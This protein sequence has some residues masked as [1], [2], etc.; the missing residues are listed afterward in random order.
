VRTR[1]AVLLWNLA[2]AVA[3]G[4]GALVFT[5]DHEDSPLATAAL[6]ISVGLA[7]VAAGLIA[8][9][10][11]PD[12]RIGLL[13]TAVGFTWFLGALAESN[14]SLLFTI[15]AAFGSI[16]FLFF[17]WLVL[18]YPSGRLLNPLDRALVGL[19]AAIAFVAHPAH[20]LVDE[21]RDERCGGAA[22]PENAF[23]VAS[24]ETLADLLLVLVQGVA[25]AVTTATVV[26]LARRWRRA[27]PALRHALT[28]VYLTAVIAVGLLATLLAADAFVDELGAGVDWVVLASL[29]AVPLAFLYGLLRTRLARSLIGRLVVE[30]GD[31]P[32]RGELRDGLARALGDP[33]L[34]LAF[35]LPESE[36][37]VDAAGRRLPVPSSDWPRHATFVERDG[38]RVA[39]LIHDAS[40][41]EEPELVETVSAAA[42]LALENER[43]LQALAAS[44]RRT[45]ALLAA[46]PDLMFRIARDGTY[47]D[48]N[49]ESDRDLATPPDQVI[50]RTVRQRLPREVADTIS[51]AIECALAGDGVQT[52]EYELV[53]Q[54]EHRHYEGRIVASGADEVLLIVREITDRKEAEAK[55]QAERD[56]LST[57]TDTTPNL[58]CVIDPAG[59]VIHVNRAVEHTIGLRAE[60]V[61][62]RRFWDAFLPPEQA[63]DFR[64]KVAQVAVEHENT[65]VDRDGVQRVIA[66]WSR[67]FVDEDG[68]ERYLLCGVDVTERKEHEREIHASR[69]RILTAEAA[70]RRRLE[71]NLHDGAQQRLVALSLSLRLARARIPKDPDDAARLLEGADAELTEALAELRELARGIHPA[72]LSDRGLEPALENL[73]AHSP[74][75]VEL[76]LPS[77]RLPQPVEAA[78]YFVVSEALANVVK[79]ADATSVHVSVA[80]NNGRVLVDVADDG[81]GGADP[82]RGSGLRGL[83]DRLSAL[84]G[85]LEVESP[86]GQGTRVRAQIPVT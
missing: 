63:D 36:S 4:A 71:R 34:E 8:W 41:L 10:R 57:V 13:M 49:A 26:I 14:S 19:V 81:V 76:E 16:P 54:G 30:L 3:V 31:D 23:L 20:L 52:V 44:D 69:Q 82:A 86:P 72:V 33:A 50:G 67:P 32:A 60:R 22:C 48:F 21:H 28:P 83:A 47:L 35:W 70:E 56:F 46:I 85:K 73:V 7:F 74:V 51:A 68:H 78:A 80:R 18:A 29:L 40:L 24:H 15:G 12:N 75:P 43:R 2:L 37:W 65:I 77:E 61:R 9:V 5:S 25:F 39:A 66:W 62:G 6:A 11:R 42:G 55:L 84:D 17:L 79:Y 1:T 27:T 58:L 53:L 59:R 38:E 45:R 64:A